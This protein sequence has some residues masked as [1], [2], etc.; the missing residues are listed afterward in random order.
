[1]IP[2]KHPTNNIE[3]TAPAEMTDK[4]CTP[5]H[6]TRGTIEFPGTG[7]KYHCTSSY[8]KPTE[9]ELELLNDGGSV[10]LTILGSAC[11]P[12]IVETVGS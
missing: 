11:P 12:V 3:L 10:K 1:M 7:R 8:W 4:E 2:V 5:L 9:A 6:A